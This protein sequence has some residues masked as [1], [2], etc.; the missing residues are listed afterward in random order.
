MKLILKEYLINSEVDFIEEE[1][2]KIKTH[3]TVCVKAEDDIND[4]LPVLTF[5]LY[6]IN[7]NSQ[8]GNEMDD[9]R[10]LESEEFVNSKFNIL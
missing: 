10:Q 1:V 9:Q 7:L 8:T 4:V 5:D 6:V 3:L 2:K